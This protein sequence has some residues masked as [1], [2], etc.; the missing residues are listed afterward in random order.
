[1]LQAVKKNIISL[2]F[3]IHP[4]YRLFLRKRIYRNLNS[5]ALIS[6]IQ[7]LGHWFDV[8]LKKPEEIPGQWLVEMEFLLD[9]AHRIHLDIDDSLS[10]ALSRFAAAKFRLH[11]IVPVTQEKNNEEISQAIMTLEH[12]LTGRRSVRVWKDDI[13]SQTDI[14]KAIELAEW[15]PSSCNRQPWKVQLIE[16]NE[17][18]QWI[19]KFFPNDFYAK[20]PMLLVIAMDC[21]VYNTAEKHYAYL[22]AGAF[23]QNLLLAL[24]TL[25]Y[26][27]CWIGFSAWTTD[28]TINCES[29]LYEEFYSQGNIAKPYVPVSLIAVGHS[30]QIPKAIPR[31]SVNKVIISDYP[32]ENN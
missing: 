13:I 20:A 25:G 11:E 26:G 16:R 22:D 30:D 8:R 19:S 23:I 7:R 1:M 4:L 12:Q 9:E 28:G 27:A 18:K 17:Q 21:N 14:K 2:L 32:K 31:K 10:W 6:H 3:R 29:E 5:N 24:H 15:A